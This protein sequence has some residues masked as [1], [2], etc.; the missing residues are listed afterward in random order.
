M[1]SATNKPF[2]SELALRLGQAPDGAVSDHV[3]Q[4]IYALSGRPDMAKLSLMMAYVTANDSLAISYL[5][6]ISH[7]RNLNIEESVDMV[8]EEMHA[9]I[10]DDFGEV[11]AFEVLVE[12]L[13]D[14][15]DELFER[16]AAVRRFAR[17]GYQFD[18]LIV[19]EGKAA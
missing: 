2:S 5:A 8:I 7:G 13:F 16:M 14:P 9:I 17:E 6:A 18:D 4:V 19:P 12:P 11:A 15:A 1:L 10:A 3:A